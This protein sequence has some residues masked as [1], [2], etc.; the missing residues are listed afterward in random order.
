[1]SGRWL[2]C[3]LQHLVNFT[4]NENVQ[5]CKL[6]VSDSECLSE[7]FKHLA[8]KSVQNFDLNLPNSKLWHKIFCGLLWCENIIDFRQNSWKSLLSS[9]F[10][11]VISKIQ[12]SKNLHIEDF[13]W[14]HNFFTGARQF[15]H[16]LTIFGS[17]LKMS[18]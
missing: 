9:I 13:V 7:K 2:I 11:N 6:F 3:L 15:L 8:G 12:G 18:T 17:F 14:R 1:M 10:Y 5:K 16:F 4:Y